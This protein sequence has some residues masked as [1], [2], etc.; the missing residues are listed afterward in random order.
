MSY[1]GR[2]NHGTLLSAPQT[3]NLK[4][5]REGE[6]FDSLIQ[7]IQ[8]SYGIQLATEAQEMAWSPSTRANDLGK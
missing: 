6:N 8:D 2:T 1:D 4:R 7:K 5:S 3:R